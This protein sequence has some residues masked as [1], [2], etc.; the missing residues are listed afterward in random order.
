MDVVLSRLEQIVVRL[1]AVEAKIGAG[2]AGG[3]PAGAA[4]AGGAAA[5]AGVE[6][7]AARAWDDLIASY[8]APFVATTNKIGGDN[9]KKQVELLSN[10]NDEIRKLINVASQAK[11]PSVDKLKELIAPIAAVVK[12]VKELRESNR[13]DKQW[14]HLSTLS[15]AVAYVNWVVV[16]PTPAPFV[17]ESLDSSLFWSNKILGLF[18]GKDQNHIDWCNQLK[19]FFNEQMK[20]IKQYHTTGLAWNANGKDV[21]AVSAA[22]AAPAA[23]PA[24][25][26]GPPGPPPPPSAEF[27]KAAAA[28][29]PKKPAGGDPSALFA[30]LNK[31]EGVT[32]G[33]KKVTKDMQTHKN[34]A[35]RAGG[36]VKSVEK[37]T[38]KPK[39]SATAAPAKKVEPKGPVLEGNKWVIEHHVG[40]NNLVIPAEE[41]EAKH[42][43]YI[44]KCERST[45]Q[46]PG[47]ANS[48]II[49]GGKRIGVAFND[50]ISGIEIVNSQSVKVQSQGKIPN[51]AVDKSSSVQI[52]LSKD[53]MNA[54]VVTSKCD[55]VNIMFPH[56]DDFTELPVP[57]QF[58]TT[59]DKDGKLKTVTM[60]HE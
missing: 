60:E 25:P 22:P 51:F 26:R 16:T 59:V 35:L 18:K 13:K 49:D 4:P 24:P 9:V 47:K 40:N 50:I 10:A 44:F 45:V 11:Q 32:S 21:D 28:P 43:I 20:Y 31:G 5:A 37:E 12:G 27:L 41:L 8:W 42:A 46:V 53:S 3:A 54:Q 14:E 1:E 29:A 15:E 52:I 2:G 6:S 55:S 34:P 58:I 30:E 38:E 17:K 23:A 19:E 36:V 56:G 39:A 33:L 7:P 57:E 48:I